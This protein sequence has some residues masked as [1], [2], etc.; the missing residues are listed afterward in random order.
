MNRRSIGAPCVEMV[1][2][3]DRSYDSGF[4][5]ATFFFLPRFRLA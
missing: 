5:A 2:L 4:A 1:R 3:L